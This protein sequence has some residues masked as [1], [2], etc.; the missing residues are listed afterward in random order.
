MGIAYTTSEF[1]YDEEG[2]GTAAAEAIG[3][4]AGQVFKTLAATGEKN[5]VLIF[6]VPVSAELNLKKAALAAGDKKVAML[7]LKGLLAA[8]GYVRGGCSPIGMKKK[9]PT[10]VDDSALNCEEIAVN[11]G[12]RGLMARLSP[13]GLLLAAEASVADLTD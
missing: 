10:F 8:T 7:P 6:V 1:A 2:G 11:A 4:P 3:M 9:Y 13:Q 5:G 12:K